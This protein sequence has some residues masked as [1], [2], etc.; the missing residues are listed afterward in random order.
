[1]DH[2]QIILLLWYFTGTKTSSQHR[3]NN[4]C[5]NFQ[6]FQNI[7]YSQNCWYN[8]D[9]YAAPVSYVNIY[10]IITHKRRKL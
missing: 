10:I 8:P 9:V 4:V 2:K 6:D 7:Q 1:M 3:E 5:K